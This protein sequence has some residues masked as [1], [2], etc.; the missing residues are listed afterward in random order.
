MM[1]NNEPNINN[2]HKIFVF[3]IQANLVNTIMVRRYMRK[4]SAY[5]IESARWCIWSDYIIFVGAPTISKTICQHTA[6]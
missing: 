5:A 3:L 6:Q 1:Y 2:Q 4:Y